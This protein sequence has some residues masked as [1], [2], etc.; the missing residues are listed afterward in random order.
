MTATLRILGCV[1]A[2]LMAS[3]SASNAA[4]ANRDAHAAPIVIGHRG[5]SGYVPEHTL[6]AYYIAIQQGADYVE[7]DL[8]MTKDGVLV[9]RHENEIGGT[10][11]VAEFPEFA[12]R[13]ATKVIDGNSVT[14]WFTEDF[15]L[16]ELKR[17]RAKERIPQVRPDNT[18]FDGQFEIPTLKEVLSLVRC[19]NEERE[20]LA[21][22]TGKRD[23]RPIGIYPE[24]KHP[25]Y[26]DALDLSMEEPLLSALR[27]FGYDSKRD[28]VFIQS[29]EVANLMQLKDMT[30]L[31][32]VQ[33]LDA[34][35]A[36]YD[37]I[38]NGDSRTYAD[39]VTS[40]GLA[41]IAKYADGV[42]LNKNLVIPRASDGRLGTPT[43]VVSRAHKAGL[44]VHVWT[45]RA[46]NTFLP[47]D[48]RFGEDPA[49]LGDMA[50]EAR[51]FLQ[52]GVDGYFTDHPNL[53]V[54]ARDAFV[55]AMK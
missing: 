39:L 46:E 49:V 13:K 11:N 48:L 34:S 15:T 8:V 30:R 16:A 44:K 27:Q 51:A 6:S 25:S 40:K 50:A 5:A 18:R 19:A 1:T 22:R 45:L 47:A 4:A 21:R 41:F 55:D 42:G 33:L 9:A 43:P 3:S 7:P 53:G 32:L 17:L 38:A 10:T 23:F 26:F 28:P 52:V 29:F 12:S 14:G 31:K 2:V 37:F 36:P 54:L 24:T 20:K 35:G